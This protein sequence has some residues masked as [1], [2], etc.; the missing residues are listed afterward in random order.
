MAVIVGF[1]VALIVLDLVAIRFAA[2]S[3]DDRHQAWW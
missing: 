3:R 2:D 1:F